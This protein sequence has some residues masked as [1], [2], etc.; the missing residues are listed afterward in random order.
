MHKLLR[1]PFRAIYSQSYNSVLDMRTGFFH[2]YGRTKNEEPKWCQ[3]GPEIADIE[4]STGDC[5]GGCPHC[6]K[7]NVASNGKHM[8]ERTFQ[9]I[10]EMLPDTVGQIALG[11][12]DPDR[13]PQLVDILRACREYDIVPNLT[14]SAPGCRQLSTISAIRNLAGAVAVSVY[15]HVG[16]EESVRLIEQL[17]E[18]N[19]H[20]TENPLQVNVHLLY[21][22]DNIAFVKRAMDA[23]AGVRFR[24]VV[25]LGLKPMGLAKDMAPATYEQFA[26]IVSHG[27][28]RGFALG[29]DSC[30]AHKFLR[31]AEEHPGLDIR[32]EWIEPC[33]S[34]LFSIYIDVDGIAYPC[35]FSVG[36]VDGVEM[37]TKPDFVYVWTSQP[38]AE[39]RKKLL[40]NDRHCPLY[41]IDS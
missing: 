15:E 31:Y 16:L 41:E 6:Y 35:S 12:T 37:L 1:Y 13:H 10:L 3:F 14:V 18:M 33:E 26:E 23:L 8:S 20:R 4:I 25:L 27:L 5:S 19:I 32:R 24:A 7:S 30:S 2:R 38:F 29:S 22:K 17:S 39:F 21:H 36:K 28:A 9:S 11:V 34:S 40:E